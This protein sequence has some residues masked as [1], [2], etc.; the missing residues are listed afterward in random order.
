[1]GLVKQQLRSFATWKLDHILRDSNERAEELAIVATSIPIKETVFLPIYHQ[2]ASSITTNR[3]SQIDEACTSWL[4]PMMHYLSL[5]KMLDNRVKAHKVQ[6][7]AARFSLVNWKL[8]KWS[9][10]GPYLRCLTTQ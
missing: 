6:V 1:M 4:A 2:S 8:Y 9:L 7:Q 3:V 5:R 10:D